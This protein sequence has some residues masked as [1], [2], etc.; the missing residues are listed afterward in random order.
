MSTYILPS[1]AKTPL[2]L[3][4]EQQQPLASTPPCPTVEQQ[5]QPPLTSTPLCPTVEQQVQP[6]LTSMPPCPTVEQQAQLPL[7]ST[8]VCPTVDQQEQPLLT[9]TTPMSTEDQCPSGDIRKKE[10][11]FTEVVSRRQVSP[12]RDPRIQ[13]VCD[14]MSR[15]GTMLKPPRTAST[16]RP[17]KTEYVP[18]P[19]KQRPPP[20]P[21]QGPVGPWVYGS[22]RPPPRTAAGP[23]SYPLQPAKYLSRSASGTPSRLP[24]F[25]K[26]PCPRVPPLASTSLSPRDPSPRVMQSSRIASPSL[27]QR[28]PPHRAI[29]APLVASRASSLPRPSSAQRVPSSGAMRS[30]RVA[31]T[32]ASSSSNFQRRPSPATTAPC[33]PSSRDKKSRSPP[34]DPTRSEVYYTERTLCVSFK[35]I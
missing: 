27:A 12:G 13:E 29:Q 21:V 32:A 20:E 11:R 6:P 5:A 4:Q 30:T 17:P 8:R 23:I 2:Q 9:S 31:P 33:R 10:V 3:Q 34:L 35:I 25:Q 24:T 7:T 28:G 16:Y 22:C 26:G 1:R 19:P 14:R 18:P 15:Y